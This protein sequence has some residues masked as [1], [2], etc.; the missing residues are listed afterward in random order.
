V[1]VSNHPQLAGGSHLPDITVI[2]P[3]FEGGQIVFFVASRGHHAGEGGCG[4]AWAGA[5]QCGKS[6]AWV[7]GWLPCVSGSGSLCCGRS[8]AL[9]VTELPLCEQATASKLPVSPPQPTPD[10]STQYA[11]T[12][13]SM[14]FFLLQTSVASPRAACRLTRTPWKRRG[15]QSSLTSWCRW[16]RVGW[17]EGTGGSGMARW[18]CE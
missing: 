10:N 12:A 7:C 11:A 9:T 15:P 1:L 5:W 3:V 18:A 8:L 17:G 13:C 4:D 6:A 2:T 14:P 16:G